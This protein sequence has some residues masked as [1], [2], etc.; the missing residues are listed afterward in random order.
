M[1]INGYE[2]TAE[3][4]STDWWSLDDDGNLEEHV[5]DGSHFKITGYNFQGET[6]DDSFFVQSDEADV[7]LLTEFVHNREIYL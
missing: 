5:E 6:M 2:V 7:D 4:E 1:K 3:V